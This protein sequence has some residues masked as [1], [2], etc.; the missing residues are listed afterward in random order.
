MELVH[1]GYILQAETT[2]EP[3]RVCTFTAL[4][5]LASGKLLA[6]FRLGGAKDSADGNCMVAESCDA[7]V[8]WQIVCEGFATDLEGVAGEIRAAEIAELEPGQLVAVLSWVNRSQGDGPFFDSGTETPLPIRLLTARSQDG[9]RTWGSYHAPGLGPLQRASVTGPPVRLPDGPWLLPFESFSKREDG[10]EAQST[11][12][13]LTRDGE[14]IDRVVTVAE[15][16]QHAHYYWDQRLAWSAAR[17]KPVA[18]FWTYDREGEADLPIHIAWGAP[19]GQAW[20]PPRSTGIRGQIAAPIPLPDGRLLAFYVHRHSPGSLRLIASED[21]GSTW[22]KS[23]EIVVYEQAAGR[24]SARGERD[25]T[26]YWDE[27]AAWTFGHPAG[28]VLDERTVL[29]AYYAGDSDTCLSAR[30]ARVEV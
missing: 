8:S 17:R 30:W 24:S 4:S 13:L 1:E 12:A 18:M 29:L 19:D 5:R 15:H 25:F 9:G 10:A 7:G 3:R 6:T 20:E 28:L 27:M 22:D 23:G 2:P 11:N 21:D 16:P 14:S 26:Q